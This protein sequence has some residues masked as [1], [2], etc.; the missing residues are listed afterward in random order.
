MLEL[1]YCL[2]RLVAAYSFIVFVLEYY[3]G[4]RIRLSRAALDDPV[5]CKTSI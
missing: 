2:E 4:L 3:A 5:L 1:S